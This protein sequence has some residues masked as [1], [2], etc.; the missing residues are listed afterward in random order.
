MEQAEH[1]ANRRLVMRA[2]AG[3]MD[4]YEEMYRYYVDD[5]TR[6]ART[7][8]NSSDEATDIVFEAFARLLVRLREDGG[9]PVDVTDYLRVAVRRLAI[10]RHHDSK[11]REQYPPGADDPIDVE[12]NGLSRIRS[13]YEA[14]P[15]DWQQM[16]WHAEVERKS[17]VELS[18]GLDMS[19]S[20]V[21]TLILR[22]R[23]GLRQAYS[24][25]ALADNDR[26][27]CRELAPNLS[28]YVKGSAPEAMEREIHNHLDECED[29]RC[30]RDDYTLLIS[31]LRQTLYSALVRPADTQAVAPAL[32]AAVE[33]EEA[34]VSGT[35]VAP[36]TRPA[37]AVS[38]VPS[39]G[40]DTATTDVSAL[41][42]PPTAPP[43]VDLPI[44]LP[45]ADEVFVDSAT[46]STA[47][48]A[49]V[50]PIAAPDA[51]ERRPRHRRRVKAI[52]VGA[53]AIAAA[54]VVA[55]FAMANRGA[56]GDP[57]ADGLDETAYDGSA[58]SDGVEGSGKV[59]GPVVKVS[60]EADDERE[61]DGVD[62]D[63]SSW[64]PTTPT[65]EATTPE[66]TA[67]PSETPSESG[68]SPAFTSGPQSVSATPGDQ[69]RF[70]IGV[71]GSP[72]PTVQW[73]KR[74][75][76]GAS[77]SNVAGARS[78][79]LA[80]SV[81][82]E[83]DGQ[84]FRAVATNSEGSTPS[85]AATITVAYAP[86][87]TAHPADATTEP[88]GSATFEASATAQPEITS[89][90]WQRNV[91]SGWTDMDISVPAA[92]NSSMTV[93]GVTADLDGSRYRA[94]FANDHGTVA[95]SAATLTV[96]QPKAEDS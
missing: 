27:L 13:A 9:L 26:E 72:A 88:G 21:A 49:P 33:H 43:Q 6:V 68:L 76:S 89:V 81:T 54:T 35:V 44:A 46:A 28:I 18:R 16:L 1:T 32:A 7:V 86:S 94:V 87:I 63:T 83:S 14:I 5:V 31:G 80:V 60:S 41:V 2:S 23:E 29:C 59:A 10:D 85:S 93:S 56:P 74:A 15:D 79:T 57:V 75:S 25:M 30:F 19:T 90:T 39:E 67:S 4:A 71:S 64:P 47:L 78:K 92:E 45:L 11:K 95:T 42:S 3:D 61:D 73:Q 17:Q 53:G 36:A 50:V 55:A 34:G 24:A 62:D 69:V 84:Q 8:A 82:S 12:P 65:D 52:A 91:G 77:W 20:A 96:S 48:S 22:A 37:P 70:T 51:G 66:D 38:N 40:I 58:V